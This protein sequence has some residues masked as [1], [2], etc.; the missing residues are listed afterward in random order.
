MYIYDNISLE[1]IVKH[2]VICGLSGS[3]IFFHIILRTVRFSENYIQ[4]KMCFDFLYNFRLKIP[5]SKMNWATRAAACGGT[6]SC[7]KQTP[8]LVRPL[9][10][11]LISC[12]SFSSVPE[13]DSAL[14]F[15]F[16]A[17]KELFSWKSCL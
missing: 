12:L 2:I 13:Y 8:L 3:I 14:R 5:H 11:F 4:H 9:C 15:S 7:N 6:L 10:R 1:H 17:G 16:L